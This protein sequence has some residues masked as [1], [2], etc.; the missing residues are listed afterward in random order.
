MNSVPSFLKPVDPSEG[1]GSGSALSERPRGR[2]VTAPAVG[3]VVPVCS[4]T[5]SAGAVVVVS[6]ALSTTALSPGATGE[7][8]G[9]ATCGTT[10]WGVTL[11][12]AGE[13]ATTGSVVEEA[14]D[15]V[16]TATEVG[17]PVVGVVVEMVVGI[18]VVVV[19]VGTTGFNV[20]CFI[21]VNARTFGVV[22]SKSLS[23]PTVTSYFEPSLPTVQFVSTIRSAA[24][25]AC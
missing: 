19:V 5:D 24:A 1:V 20:Q 4:V 10:T 8:D 21:S 18:V 7:S 15:V 9:M 2:G 6:R 23:P 25:S 11:G 22:G 14:E 12:A 13:E 17:V 16:V 3:V